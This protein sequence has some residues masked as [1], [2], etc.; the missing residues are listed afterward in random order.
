MWTWSGSC[1]AGEV[2]TEPKKWKNS[3]QLDKWNMKEKYMCKDRDEKEYILK[4]FLPSV[5]GRKTHDH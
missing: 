1:Y 3:S 2:T 5:F 4:H